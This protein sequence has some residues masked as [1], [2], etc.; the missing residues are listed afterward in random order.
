LLISF[1]PAAQAYEDLLLAQADTGANGTEGN[2]VEDL[3]IESFG[4]PEGY[5][6]E[7]IQ[8]STILPELSLYEALALSLEYNRS[9]GARELG[10]ESAYSERRSSMSE[11]LPD[12]SAFYNYTRYDS[13]SVVSTPDFEFTMRGLVSTRWGLSF[14][15]PIYNGGRRSALRRSSN[16]S[17]R[18]AEFDLLVEQAYETLDVIQAFMNVLEIGAALEA[19]EKS[20]EHLDEVGRTAQANFD[21]GLI[22]LNNL[23][24][25]QVARSQLAQSVNGMG[26]NL[27]IAKSALAI[28]VTGDLTDRWILVPV[29]F[30]ETEIPYPIE[31]LWDWALANR[32]SLKSL[33]ANRDALAARIDSIRS[34]RIPGLS[35]NADYSGSGGDLSASDGTLSGTLTLYWDLYDFGSVDDR[36][37]PLETQLELIDLQRDALETLVRQQVE[38]GFLFVKTQ[39]G[40][41]E[42]GREALVQAREAARVA[43]RRQE[44][45]LGL[46]IEVLD[47]EATLAQTDLNYIQVLYDY[48]TGLAGL[49]RAV[50][51][52]TSDLIAL[53][54]AAKE[55]Q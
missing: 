12:L 17:I 27:E 37:A 3:L 28:L 11:F 40:N 34:S 19:M 48:Y 55:A 2:P 4:D 49:S 1:S 26:N 29:E 54:I 53:I 32:P 38:Q 45:G 18:A 33:D 51:M 52:P 14:S 39:L 35:L 24:A 30:P 21:A 43:R 41:L 44:E 50:G 6:D 42:V 15:Y 16:A 31:I 25:A 9:I 23:L 7:E 22:P 5:E 47:A 46:M 8:V 13:A 10:I 20:L 36:I